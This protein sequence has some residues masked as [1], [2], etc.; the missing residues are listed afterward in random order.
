MIVFLWD[1]ISAPYTFMFK[2]N[3]DNNSLSCKQLEYRLFTRLDFIQKFEILVRKVV[4]FTVNWYKKII[5][6][7]VKRW[8]SSKQYHC[9]EIAEYNK[10]ITN[11]EK[12]DSLSF[13]QVYFLYKVALYNSLDIR[14]NNTDKHNTL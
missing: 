13:R 5:N 10:L 6:I 2:I 1:D 8:V 3:S 9:K 14:I 7:V 12:E 11:L 4:N